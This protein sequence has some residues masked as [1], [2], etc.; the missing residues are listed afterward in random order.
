MKKCKHYNECMKNYV[1]ECDEYWDCYN[2]YRE[3][4]DKEE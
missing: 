4:E 1:F 2:E 3:K